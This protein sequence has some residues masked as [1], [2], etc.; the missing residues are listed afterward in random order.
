VKSFVRSFVF[1]YISLTVVQSLLKGFS[2]E[3][4]AMLFVVLAFTLLDFF[5]V[6]I[7]KTV[8]LP[9]K[10]PVFIIINSFLVF[11]TS[12][13]LTLFIPN[14]S[15]VATTTPQLIIFGFMIPSKSLTPLFAAAATA[16]FYSVSLSFL[17][18][19]GRCKR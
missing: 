12:F 5:M 3:L 4:K 6:P 14:F 7:L 17:N 1:A 18:W 10:G 11:T 9:E 16:F 2:L 15:F 8:S 13:L 19:L